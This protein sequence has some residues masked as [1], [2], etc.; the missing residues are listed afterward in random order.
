MGGSWRTIDDGEFE[1]E[2]AAVRERVFGRRFWANGKDRYPFANRDWQ[3]VPL[4]WTF[5]FPNAPGFGG[6]SD[7]PPFDPDVV[8][9]LDALCWT[10]EEFNIGEVVISQ[11]ALG[12]AMIEADGTIVFDVDWDFGA[13][14]EAHRLVW[15]AER[16][17][18]GFEFE[19]FMRLFAL[20][21]SE[22]RWGMLVDD[23]G[24]G[25]GDRYCYSVLGGDRAFIE[26]FYD[27]AGGERNVRAWFTYDLL[28]G[29][30]CGLRG[31]GV[32]RMRRDVK[33]IYRQ[34]GWPLPRR[35]HLRRNEKVDW[36]WMLNDEGFPTK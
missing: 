27:L 9:Y 29:R 33:R 22:G 21:S 20:F 6:W 2:F 35:W 26:T 16:I 10:L 36:S 17:F 25:Y 8:N 18:E 15:P 7:D 14:G 1:R 23:V 12:G 30:G 4:P 3:I 32:A 5:I 31:R 34:A 13:A 19:E 24:F 11:R 28:C